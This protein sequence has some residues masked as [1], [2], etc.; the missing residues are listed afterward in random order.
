MADRPTCATCRFFDPHEED[1]IHYG[2]CR[3]A[4]PI[5]VAGVTRWPLVKTEDWCGKHD[6]P[7]DPAA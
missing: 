5:V 1:P 6:A 4:P 2:L 3:V 7:K